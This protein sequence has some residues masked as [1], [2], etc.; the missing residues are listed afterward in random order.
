M[1][2]ARRQLM[3]LL[4]FAAGASTAQ[5]RDL[6][7][8]SVESISKRYGPPSRVTSTE[9]DRPRPALVTRFVEYERQ[10]VRF[11][12]L[13]DAPIG[14]APPYQHWVLMGV[15]DLKTKKSLTAEEVERRFRK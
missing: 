5:K 10:A 14:T 15:Q 9:N 1:R 11:V 12:L 2:T 6:P 3:V 7:R 8:V 4:L 13:A